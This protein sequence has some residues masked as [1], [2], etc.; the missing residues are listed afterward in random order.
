MDF[1]LASQANSVIRLDRLEEDLTRQK[2]SLDVLVRVSSDLV[3][4]SSSLIDRT[5]RLASRSDS[6]DEMIKVLRELLET[7]LRRPDN[8]QQAS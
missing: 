1:I 4:V 8:P 3:K 2:E 5:K 7:N 6:F